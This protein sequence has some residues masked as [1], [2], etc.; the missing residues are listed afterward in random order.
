MC[1]F[2]GNFGE[3]LEGCVYDL[4]CPSFLANQSAWY[5]LIFARPITCLVT[6]TQPLRQVCNDP[7]TDVY[8]RL[9]VG[10]RS[11]TI[12]LGVNMAKRLAIMAH[13][14]VNVAVC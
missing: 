10:N 12:F 2:D 13:L 3:G 5:K 9:T 11:K 14:R 1:A 4:L 6:S 7:Q 8:L